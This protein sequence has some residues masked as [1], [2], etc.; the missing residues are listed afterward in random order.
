MRQIS[1]LNM[2]GNVKKKKKPTKKP[3]L[4][5][6]AGYAFFYFS[7]LSLYQKV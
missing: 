4:F 5:P 2:K 7:F 3:N 1:V 6:D